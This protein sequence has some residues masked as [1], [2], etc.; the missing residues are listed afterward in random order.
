MLFENFNE[1]L[2]KVTSFLTLVDF[3]NESIDPIP[4]DI[5]FFINSSKDFRNHYFSRERLSC[6]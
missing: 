4:R 6:I 5:L 3:F 2:L 1:Q